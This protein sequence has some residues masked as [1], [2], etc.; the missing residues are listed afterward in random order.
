MEN[1]PVLTTPRTRVLVVVEPHPEAGR[2]L[3]AARRKARECGADWEAV[4]VDSPAILKKLSVEDREQ[5]SQ[6]LAL[7][8]QIGGVVTKM[9]EK[10]TITGILKLLAQ[11]EV[12]DIQ[13]ITI[14]IGSSQKISGFKFFRPSLE[15]QLHHHINDSY[16]IVTI[17]LGQETIINSRLATLFHVAPREILISLGA[18]ILATCVIEL[19]AYL[20][21]DVIINMQHRNKSII[22]MTACAFASIRYGMLAGIIAAVASFLMLRLLYISPNFSL[23]IHDVG[24]A[25]NLALFLLAATLISFFGSREHELKEQL[26]LRASRFQSLLRLHKITLD[27]QTPVEATEA[28]AEELAR[29]LHMEVAFFLSSKEDPSQ[30]QTF[31]SKDIN[32]SDSEKAARM[33]CWEESKPTGAGTG[34]Y[35]ASNWRFEPLLTAAGEIGVLGVRMEGLPQLDAAFNYLLSS[36]A[37]QAALIL[38]RLEIGK[39]AELTRL[40][41]EREKLR[42]M[43]LSS[44]SHDLKTPLA[45][46]IGSLSVYRNMGSKLS[47]EQRGILID[48]ALEEA[49]RLDSF[50]TNILDM[51]RIESGQITMKSEWINPFGLIED[52]RKRLRDRLRQ[53]EIVIHQ[54]ATDIEVCMDSMMTGQV[55][56]NLIDNAVKYTPAG[57]RIDISMRVTEK[58]FLMEVRDR[59]PGIPPDKLEK[60]FD[61]YARIRRQDSQVA[62]T[63]LGLAIA[64]ATIQA[65]G[66]TIMASNHPE[67]GAIFTLTLPKWRKQAVERRFA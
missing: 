40:Q 59:G 46:V 17:R 38:E 6:T 20:W 49:Q 60:V 19:L 50:I 52:V 30:L 62:G 16:E 36:I 41:A 12:Q 51:T 43:L 67:G 39:T 57:T 1:N 47:E 14:L 7:A 29:L 35:S 56:Q 13:I 31:A 11:R 26:L 21:P 28:L 32:L 8:E 2:L 3:R 5:L 54:S 24:D 44:V 10:S 18:V 15:S 61:K 42:A 4:F 45:S 9:N 65:Q 66:G 58:H 34:F 22:Y 27:K 64:R 25:V 23:T 48:T 55:V 63:G 53:H 37:N 33:L